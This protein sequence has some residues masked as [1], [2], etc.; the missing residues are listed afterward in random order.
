MPSVELARNQIYKKQI[1][2]EINFSDTE[3]QDDVI[4]LQDKKL[5]SCSDHTL[6]IVMILFLLSI[7]H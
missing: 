3:C 7:L 5:Q 4:H 2:K 6:K 1:S